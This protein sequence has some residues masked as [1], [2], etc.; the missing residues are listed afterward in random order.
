MESTDRMN[1]LRN[2]LKHLVLHR[3]PKLLVALEHCHDEAGFLLNGRYVPFGL[4]GDWKE[5]LE[6]EGYNPNYCVWEPCCLTPHGP[7]VLARFR[8]IDLVRAK[9]ISPKSWL[10]EK[11]VLTSF[12]S[13]NT[14]GKSN[15]DVESR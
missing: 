9:Q 7:E 10:I 12:P 3:T 15:A 8:L 1:S 6:E 13:I 14:Q 5:R 4:D 11:N 2:R